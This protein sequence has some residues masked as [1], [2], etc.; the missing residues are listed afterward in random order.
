MTYTRG[1][2]SATQAAR[3][4]AER[5]RAEVERLYA[6]GRALAQTAKQLRQRNANLE[7]K[8][9]EERERL[10]DKRARLAQTLADLATA[11]EEA[12]ATIREAEEKA[13]LIRELAFDQ[14]RALAERAYA[15]GYSRG[16]D[17]A[18][19]MH[20]TIQRHMPRLTREAPRKGISTNSTHG[21]TT[22]VP[23]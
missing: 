19:A 12:D 21:V 1:I 8:V 17:H 20:A 2:A 11:Q 23:A 13:G 6:E 5:E 7:A 9:T 14:A 16:K 10:E 4:A 18:R 15:A 22:R 3:A